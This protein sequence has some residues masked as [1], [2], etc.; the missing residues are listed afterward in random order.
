MAEI[1]LISHSDI[2]KFTALNG[3]VDV[4]KYIGF[5]KIAQDIHVQ[6]Y[7]GTNL[8]NKIKTDIQNNVLASPYTTLVNTYIKPMLLH[9]SL[10]EYLPYSAYT[11]ANKGVYKHGAENS[12]SV[13][14]NELEFLINKQESVANHYTTRMIK[15][16]CSYSN[17]FP[18]YS[19]TNNGE[20]QSD[21]DNNFTSWHL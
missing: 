20:M 11:I 5:V 21:R 4:D 14:K 19:V 15:Y 3:S 2:V 8:F 9:W 17:L 10:V 18:E 6:N 7:L 1:L 16:L 12:Q 13:E